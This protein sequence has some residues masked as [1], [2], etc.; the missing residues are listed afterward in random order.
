MDE[1]IT[2]LKT[3]PYE[4]ALEILGRIRSSDDVQTVVALIRERDVLLQPISPDSTSAADVTSQA[5]EELITDSGSSKNHYLDDWIKQR[6]AACK[7]FIEGKYLDAEINYRALIHEFEGFPG[8]NNSELFD[9]QSCLLNTLVSQGKFVEAEAFYKPIFH[10]RVE[11]FGENHGHTGTAMYWYAMTQFY[12]YNFREADGLLWKAY[13]IIKAAFGEMHQHTLEAEY[14]LVRALLMLSRYEEAERQLR[15]TI[16]KHEQMF[17]PDSPKTLFCAME[18]GHVLHCLKKYGEDELI[19]ESTLARMEKSNSLD[20]RNKFLC[21]QRLAQILRRCG[22]LEDARKLFTAALSIATQNYA[23]DFTFEQKL[24]KECLEEVVKELE[25]NKLVHTAFL[26]A[27][28]RL[29]SGFFDDNRTQ[30]YTDSDI[31]EISSL[32]KPLNDHWHKVPRTYII[33]RKMKRLDLL[34]NLIELGFADYWF[35][36]TEE[37]LPA[38]FASPALRSHFVRTQNIILTNSIDI[39]QGERGRHRHFA[40]NDPLPFERIRLLGSGGFGEVD[41]VRSLIT[42]REYARKRVPRSV[43]PRGRGAEAIKCLISEIEVMKRLRHHHIVEL[44]G[45]YTDLRYLGLIMSP[46]AEM[47][48]A[49]YLKQV[50]YS[51]FPELRTFFGCLAS[52]LSYL[53]NSGTRHKDIKPRNILV[54]QGSVLLTDF[55]LSFDFSDETGSTTNGTVKAF[56]PKYCA[57]E[58]AYGEPRNTASDVWSLGVVFLEMAVIL[59]SGLHCDIDDYFE[60]NGIGRRF[61]RDNPTALDK[62]LTELEK[63][64]CRED[65]QLLSWIYAMLE[66]NPR[67][68]P[69]AAS[70]F[71]M[72]TSTEVNVAFCGICCRESDHIPSD[73]ELEDYFK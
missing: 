38:V 50:E 66:T 63:T 29:L 60:N 3:K 6:D 57:P 5:I 62:L 61:V 11:I 59:K 28:P 31:S 2:C 67:S 54:H 14:G 18:L 17:G 19:W 45:S 56:S 15:I 36:V 37:S 12:L 33:L 25:S 73:D 40:K 13:P 23:T 72:M 27:T 39:E 1:L 16:P 22:K 49:E 20:R 8:I 21:Q 68:R 51:S 52:A 42:F 30:P 41:Q 48:L 44:V 58:V 10:Q 43:A 35:P 70:L 7:N 55:G 9:I 64:G 34:D 26:N 46:I 32:L 47:D 71:A 65:N 69:S 4:E 53:H 24:I